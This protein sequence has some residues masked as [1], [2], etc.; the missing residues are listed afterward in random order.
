MRDWI[1][2]G[3]SLLGFVIVVIGFVPLVRARRSSKPAGRSPKARRALAWFIAGLLVMES[4]Q[5][6]RA[7]GWLGA[8][9]HVI[10]IVLLVTGSL[11]LRRDRRTG[12]AARRG[13]ERG[14]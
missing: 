1:G 12:P 10:V 6:I 14:K 13:P 4:G 2:T 3:V 5:L 8:I 7:H 9:L 11:L